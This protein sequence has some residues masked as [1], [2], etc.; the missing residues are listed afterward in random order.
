MTFADS[1]LTLRHA[2]S[3]FTYA[4]QALPALG[5]VSVGRGWD[6]EGGGVKVKHAEEWGKT[7]YVAVFLKSLLVALVLNGE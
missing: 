1:H 3:G 6:A 5:E 4:F 7:R 2:P